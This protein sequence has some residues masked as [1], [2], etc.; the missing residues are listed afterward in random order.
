M[1]EGIVNIFKG[2]ANLIININN[3]MI[4]LII[5]A[6]AQV[7]RVAQ[8]IWNL[9]PGHKDVTWYQDIMAMGAGKNLIPTFATG[10]VMPYTGLAMVHAGETITPAGQGINSSPV[11]NINASISNDYDVRR[12]AEQLNK[13]WTSDME[14]ISKG[15][16]MI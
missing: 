11:F 1:G 3:M 8:W 6:F 16:G 13:Y 12:L 10:G 5:S 2:V 14:R 7:V 15:R 9:I 4:S